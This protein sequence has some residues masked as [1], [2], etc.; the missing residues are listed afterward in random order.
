MRPH[1]EP[2]KLRTKH[3]Q[4]GD[5]DRKGQRPPESP[6]EIFQLRIIVL[7][8]GHERLKRHA[9][10]WAA[11]RMI[12]SNLGV[13]RT[14]INCARSYLLESC[15]VLVFL[16]G[17]FFGITLERF[18]ALGATKIETLA[19]MLNLIYGVFRHWHTAHRIG[20]LQA[21]GGLRHVVVVRFR[22]VVRHGDK[23]LPRV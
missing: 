6:R 20:E 22:L 21:G 19:F 15:F 13:H 1:A 18:R 3:G 10:L 16:T 2:A 9:A 7:Q 4:H 8:A 12:L 14:G 5:N 11:S 23:N 17:E